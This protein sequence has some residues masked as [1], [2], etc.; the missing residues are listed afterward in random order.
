MGAMVLRRLWRARYPVVMT[1]WALALVML[2]VNIVF[3]QRDAPGGDDAEAAGSGLARTSSPAQA[4]GGRD[5]GTEYQV[6]RKVCMMGSGD[7]G[8]DDCTCMEG[9]GGKDCNQALCPSG[10]GHG[11]CLRPGYCACEEG[12]RGK[13]C[14]EPTC[15]K[16]CVHG[17]CR[18]P[19]FCKCEAGWYGWQCDR[20][21][22]HGVFSQRKQACVCRQGW[23]GEDCKMAYCDLTG[24]VHGYCVAPEKC[25]CFMAWAGRNCTDDLA[26][27]LADELTNGLVFRASRWPALTV[28]NSGKKF[29]ESWKWIRKWTSGLEEE[30]KFGRTRFTNELPYNDT[31]QE[32]LQDKYKTCVAVGNSGKLLDLKAGS[33]I[34][35]HELVMRFNDAPVRGYEENVGRRTT[36][37]LLNRDYADTLVARQQRRAGAPPPPPG[38][39]ARRPSDVITLM[40]R[41]ESYQHYAVLRKLLPGERIYMISPQ[42]LLPLLK[43]FKQVMERLAEKGMSGEVPQSTPHGFVGIALLMQICEKITVYGF[44]EPSKLQEAGKYHYYDRIEP[45]DPHANDVEFSVL[46]ILDGLGIIRLCLPDE[47]E[48]CVGEDQVHF[49]LT[50]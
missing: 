8:E 5:Q 24:C 15:K 40:W 39:K 27:S 35:A 7:E 21:C 2:S 45:L 10:C 13:Q 36:I 4:W 9:Y 32:V 14:G 11:K 30:W 44:E 3:N 16:R 29:D 1:V 19:N 37:R 49:G 17:N 38:K 34:D 6:D 50:E 31:F 43:F 18:Y 28:Y 22:H 12:W 48:A 26:R 46:R 33:A 42:F 41:A 23:R 47:H 25:K 20:Q